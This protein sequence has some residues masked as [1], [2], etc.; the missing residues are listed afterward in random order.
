M[1]DDRGR[2][3]RPYKEYLRHYNPYKFEA[4]RRR[5]RRLNRQ[6]ADSCLAEPQS[7]V[8]DREKEMDS[9]EVFN[10]SCAC[11]EST[12]DQW[13]VHSSEASAMEKA[14]L[15]SDEEVQE[16]LETRD[17]EL[18]RV[19]DVETSDYELLT[20]STS[21]AR[22]LR[23]DDDAS[24]DSV[25]DYEDHEDLELPSENCE[26]ES[27]DILYSG[28]PLTSSTSVVLL[29]TFVMKHKLTREAFND[30]LSVIEAHCPRPNNCKTSVKKLL[31]FVSLVKVDRLCKK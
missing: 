5:N 4:A 2:K 9:G 27:N 26:S 31:K 19:L 28:A 29:L 16:I 10:F 23:E 1:A 3:R 24:L 18:G 17:L 20:T 7:G 22:F 21:Y 8:N 13:D 25:S 14:T 12:F 30:L 11:D 15:S 6:K